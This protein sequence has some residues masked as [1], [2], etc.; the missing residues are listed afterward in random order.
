MEGRTLDG[1]VGRE[2]LRVMPAGDG[3]DRNAGHEDEEACP[4]TSMR[5]FAHSPLLFVPV[6]YFL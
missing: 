2:R 4:L 6:V 3:G 5:I 1:R